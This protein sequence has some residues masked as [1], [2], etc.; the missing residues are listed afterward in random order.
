MD[1]DIKN[2]PPVVVVL[3]HVDHGK[4]SLLE[5]VKDLKITEKESGG[6]TQHIGSYFIEHQGKGITFIDTPGHEAFSAMRSRGAKVADI[7]VLVVAADEGV[8][9]QTK[10]A[11]EHLLKA[12]MPFIIAINKMDKKDADA[13][14][15]KQAL[16]MEN[17]FV[18]SFG[19]SIPSVEI[20]AKTGEGVEGLLEMILLVAEMEDLVCDPK[21]SA[22][23][24]IIETQLDNRR[25]VSVNVIIK[26][27]TL[28]KGD[29]ISSNS[30][31]GRIK[32]IHN[33]TGEEIEEAGPSYPVSINGVK[34]S[35]QVGDSFVVCK[36]IDEARKSVNFEQLLE[37]IYET[38][39]Q[40]EFPIIIKADTNGSLE[41]IKNKIN[42]LS[43]DSI[44][45]K[46]I[47]SGVGEVNENDVCLAR[48]ANAGIFIFRVKVSN[49]AKSIALRDEVDIKNFDII[50]ELFDSV[51]E[52]GSKRIKPEKIKTEIGKF[53]IMAVFRTK[54]NRQ[55]LGGKII[56]GEAT[57]GCI[58][59]IYKGEEKMGEGKIINI[60][61]GE[62]DIEKAPIKEEV[63]LLFEGSGRAEEGDHLLIS[64][65][66]EITGSL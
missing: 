47:S 48:T 11:I 8:K 38:G 21:I 49:L 36:S 4:S 53:K 65:E 52:E 5:A 24:V 37:N 55:I 57:K 1:K 30:A 56:K 2:K 33:C 14:K 32:T 27:G 25:G 19:G 46:I 39:N 23:G 35:P 31:F 17:V 9:E 51:K 40:N 45:V 59:E 54:G 60:K 20:S 22:T 34:G 7:G 18:E 63:G 15:A 26:N 43:R 62:K 6:I 66:E 12:E 58:V 16:S 41:A 28:K 64:K 44:T 29:I 10:E 13:N 50:Y 3:G 42:S 61:K